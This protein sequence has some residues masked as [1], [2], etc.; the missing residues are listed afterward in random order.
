MRRPNE[1]FLIPVLLLCLTGCSGL[2]DVKNAGGGGGGGN[3]SSGITVSPAAP[4][5][6]A[7]GT[8]TFT[9]TVSGSSSGSVTWQVNNVTG[10]SQATGFISSSG[11]YVAPGGVPTMSNGSGDSQVTTVLVTAVSGSASGSAV[12]TITPPNQNAQSGAVKLGTSGGNVNETAGNSCCSGTLGSLVTLNGT[13]YILSNNHVLARS[14]FGIVGENISQPGLVDTNCQTAGTQNVAQLSQ[15]FNLETGPVPK[16]DAALAQVV[17][18]KVDSGGNILLLGG[19][20]TN[21]IPDAGAPHQGTGI[22]ATLGL[23]VAKSG[24]TTGL[25]C[26][27]VLA[28]QVS[29]RVDY[30]KNCG[31]TTKAFTVNYTDLVSI[32]GGAFSADGD[33]GSL[34]VSQATADPVALLFAGS[35]TDTVGN[36]VSDVLTA[37]PGTGNATPTFVGGAVHQV[38]GCT[39]PTKP[40]SAIAPK[41][42][43]AAETVR[44]AT[45]IRDLHAPELLANAAIEGIGVGR[46]Y[47][48]PGEAAIL[49][50]VNS[51]GSLEGLPK[52]INGVSTRVITGESWSLRGTLTNDESTRLLSTAAEPQL[53]Y[54][55][56][57]GELERA[58][59]VKQMHVN[60]FLSKPDVVGV[61]IASSVDAPGEA[62][63][64]IYV[65]H[66]ATLTGIP[67]EISGLR[68][69]IRETSRFSAGRDSIGA[70][71]GCRVPVSN[72]ISAQTKR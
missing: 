72:L 17:N 42:Q 70:S 34:I 25:T 2:S 24:R 51:R 68:T 3:T 9:A 62:A 61:G 22:A 47:D 67:A 1:I 45:L 71:H 54:A 69:R 13:Q 56:Q 40:A 10:G 55:L 6:Q 27:S 48:H 23:T 49:L 35:D 64:L 50:F 60:E 5:V 66:G 11:V 29:A 4:T 41:S 52:S 16:V 36:P 38:I 37:F 19:T 63:L 31:D 58:K 65:N 57:P 7:F 18:G 33:S 44:S 43:V 8:Q 53:I 28:T 39:L 46:S 15:F 14:D 21:G 26:S 12:V 20:Q 32:A 30:F 59:L